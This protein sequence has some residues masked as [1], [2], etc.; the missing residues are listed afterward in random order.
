MTAD[1]AYERFLRSVKPIGIGLVSVS[2]RLDREAYA[3]VMEQRDRG[4]RTISTD[5]KLVEVGDGYFDAS[6]RFS[7]SVAEPNKSTPALAIDCTHAAHFH[8]KTCQRELAERFTS[9]ELRLVLWPYF[10]ELVSDLCGKMAIQP[11]TIP[12]TTADDE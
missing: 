5:Y 1:A 10:R 2:S 11:I 3:H 8:C 6:A 12:L 4:T 7:L 9:S